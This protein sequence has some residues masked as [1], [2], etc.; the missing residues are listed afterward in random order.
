VIEAVFVEVDVSP[1]ESMAMGASCALIVLNVQGEVVGS[2]VSRGAV[3]ETLDGDGAIGA[4]GSMLC[5]VRV[6]RRSL[7][8]TAISIPA[9]TGYASARVVD[10]TCEG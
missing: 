5:T 7:S 8:T 10:A 3:E 4:R 6:A 2:G 9:C 1:T